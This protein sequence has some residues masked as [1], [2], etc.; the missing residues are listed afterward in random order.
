[1]LFE[2]AP[3]QSCMQRWMNSWASTQLESSESSNS[4]TSRAWAMFMSRMSKR[5]W[6]LESSK[7]SNFEAFFKPSGFQTLLVYAFELY[8]LKFPELPM[9]ENPTFD[10]AEG[11]WHDRT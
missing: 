9:H 11:I 2:E 4:Y 6:I 8:V 5:V 3:C 1:M 7:L 10:A